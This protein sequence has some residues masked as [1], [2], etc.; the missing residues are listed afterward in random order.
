MKEIAAKRKLKKLKNECRRGTHE[1]TISLRF[2]GIILSVLR[3]EVSVYKQISTHFA[4]WRRGVG[5]GGVKSFSRV[6]CEQQG[7]NLLRLLSQLRPRIQNPVEISTGSKENIL[8]GSGR[9]SASR[10]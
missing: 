3:L 7:G 6:D 4:R 1:R 2:L 5:G 9:E 10:G 8:K